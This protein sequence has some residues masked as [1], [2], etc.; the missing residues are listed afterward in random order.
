M[1]L[2]K[3]YTDAQPWNGSSQL[4]PPCSSTTQ[5]ESAPLD[6]DARDRL[7][8]PCRFRPLGGIGLNPE[9][10]HSANFR[11]RPTFLNIGK[12]NGYRPEETDLG[13]SLCG[14]DQAGPW[15]VYRSSSSRDQ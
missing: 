15:P 1:D 12:P 14:L 13:N 7:S 2:E 4:A 5:P 3:V 11:L 9:L 10:V 8:I 6:Y